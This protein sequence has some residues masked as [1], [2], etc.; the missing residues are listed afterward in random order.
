MISRLPFWLDLVIPES[1][2]KVCAEMNGS[3]CVKNEYLLHLLYKYAE[4]VA[5]VAGPL[6]E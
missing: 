5:F 4:Q 6:Y 1:I 2:C 3:F